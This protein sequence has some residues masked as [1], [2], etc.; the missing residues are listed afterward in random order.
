TIIVVFI[1]DSFVPPLFI[2]T[3]RKI[4]YISTEHPSV[5]Y[6]NTKYLKYVNLTSQRYG[7]ENPFYY[8]GLHLE[9]LIYFSNNV[10]V[11]FYFY[12]FLS[13]VYKRGFIEMHFKFCD[14]LHKDSFFG[15]PMRQGKFLQPCPYPPGSYNLYNMSID[16]RVIPPGFPFRKGRIYCN[17]TYEKTLFASGFIDM[18]VK[19]KL[20]A[21]PSPIQKIDDLDATKSHGRLSIFWGETS[22]QMGCKWRNPMEKIKRK[23]VTSVTRLYVRISWRVTR[24]RLKRYDRHTQQYHHHHHHHQPINVPTAG[25]Q[26]FPMDGIGRLGHDP[27]RGPSA[28]WW[29]LTTADAAGTNGLT[30][31]P[32]HGG[33]RDG[34]FLVTH[35]MTDHCESCLTSTIAA[36]RAK[37]LLHRNTWRPTATSHGGNVY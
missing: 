15:A 26:A 7:R 24:P 16:V 28:D 19:E 31:L 12:E 23:C 33:A 10:S 8:V 25:A 11:D 2:T 6:Y 3:A 34:K 5:T 4:R 17:L 30:C 14:L 1:L 18:E 13:N 27:P 36:D 21:K 29:V 37:H 35:P 22:F 32:K 20:Y 9:T